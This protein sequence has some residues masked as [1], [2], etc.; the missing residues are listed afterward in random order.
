MSFAGV[1]PHYITKVEKKGRTK[2]EVDEII[3]WLTGYSKKELTAILKNH[4]ILF[5]YWQHFF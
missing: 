1:Y 3:F 4:Y 2:K 5:F